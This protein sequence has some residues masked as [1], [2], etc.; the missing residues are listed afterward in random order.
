MPSKIIIIIFIHHNIHHYYS[1]RNFSIFHRF[2]HFGKNCRSVGVSAELVGL[3]FTTWFVYI[4]TLLCVG[5]DWTSAFN[6]AI[7]RYLSLSTRKYT[8]RVQMHDEIFH[9]EIFKNFVKFLKYFKTS[10]LKYFMKF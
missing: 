4:K 6:D 1:L 10:Y 7:L 5:C 2:A 8:R 9:F 3:H